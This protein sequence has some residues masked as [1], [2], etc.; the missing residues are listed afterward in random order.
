MNVGSASAV[1]AT[2]WARAVN[3]ALAFAQEKGARIIGVTGDR[4][5]VGVSLLSH[6]LALAYARHGLRVFLVD[7]S[8]TELTAVEDA[9]GRRSCSYLNDLATKTEAGILFVDFARHATHLPSDRQSMKQLFDYQSGREGAAIIVDLPAF[10]GS[11]RGIRALS[12]IGSACQLVFLMCVSGLVNRS[13]L[14]DCI[15]TSKLGQ[16]PIEGVIVNDWKQP[17]WLKIS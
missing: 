15:N 10:S 13:E 5:G 9:D 11:A 4:S 2:P 1:D 16:I 3:K 8:H 17:L 6:E 14:S 7:A 12:V